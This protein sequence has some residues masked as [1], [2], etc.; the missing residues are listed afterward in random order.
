MDSAIPK[1]DKVKSIKEGDKKE[2]TK[3]R[4]NMETRII[5]IFNEFISIIIEYAGITF[6]FQWSLILAD[7][8]TFRA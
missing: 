8:I 2:N 5:N 3:N 1:V 7:K 6:S 4:S